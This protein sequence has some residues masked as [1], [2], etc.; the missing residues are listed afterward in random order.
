MITTPP[1]TAAALEAADQNLWNLEAATEAA[2][3]FFRRDPVTPSALPA[4][5][6]EARAHATPTTGRATMATML[7]DALLA[8]PGVSVPAPIARRLLAAIT[9]AL[10]IAA[11]GKRLCTDDDH[12]ASTITGTDT[13]CARIP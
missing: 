12:T 8:A 1:D 10:T 11:R 5:R 3:R 7:V 13:P 4:L 9:A 2:A 6:L